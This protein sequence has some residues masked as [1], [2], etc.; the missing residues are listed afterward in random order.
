V[1]R[2]QCLDGSIDNQKRLVSEIAG[3]SAQMS[4]KT[5][6]ENAG[7]F[8]FETNIEVAPVLAFDLF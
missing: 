5:M 2:S 3:T 8:E 1:L 4:P 7:I 6:P